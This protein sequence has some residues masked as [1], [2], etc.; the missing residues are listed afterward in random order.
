VRVEAAAM[1]AAA[2]RMAERRTCMLFDFFGF[3]SFVC[4]LEV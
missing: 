2:G 1:R 4:V 3:A